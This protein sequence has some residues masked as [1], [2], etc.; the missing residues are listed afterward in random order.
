MIAVY[1]GHIYLSHYGYHIR[2]SKAHGK[3]ASARLKP[4]SSATET[5]WNIEILLV[6]GLVR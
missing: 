6:A 3:W 1:A 5:T 4:V 2:Y